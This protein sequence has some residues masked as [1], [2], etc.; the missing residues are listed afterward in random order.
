MK[1]DS[2]KM[3]YLSK[4]TNSIYEDLKIE[5]LYHS[6]HLE[7][8]TFSKDELEKL[9]TEKKVEGSHSL[10]DI[11]ETKNS[12]EVFDQ[13]I[14]DS[15]ELLDKFMLFNWHKLLKKGT[16]DDEIHNIGMW[17]RYENKL[18]GVDLKLALPVEVDNLMF[19]LLSD[20]NELETVTLKDIADF[21][22]KFE[23]IHPFQDG[24]GRIG[25]FIILKQCLE[26]NID[27][28]AI[29]DKYDDEY[30]EALYKAQKT[31]DSEDLVI[32]FKKCQNRL[33]EKL[34][35][36]KSLLD[37]VDIDMQN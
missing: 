18:R 20:Y 33:E 13:V 21:H 23:K 34:E 1:I 17:K 2:K 16:V 3:K 11:I 35:K 31:G 30:R 8:S 29:D 7:G 4:I 6:N 25:R 15:S 9:L 5:F 19:N 27:L 36:Y 32:V 14:N 37:Q 12:L 22:Y 26:W 28:I 24:N 10:D